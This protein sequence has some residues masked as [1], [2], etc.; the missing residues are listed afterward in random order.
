MCSLR[1]N[2]TRASFARIVLQDTLPAK[3]REEKERQ[4][5]ALE[6]QRGDVQQSQL[7]AKMVTRYRKVKFFEK[8]KLVRRGQA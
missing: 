3:V 1:R 2:D 6:R 4:L 8:Q 5:E 7:E